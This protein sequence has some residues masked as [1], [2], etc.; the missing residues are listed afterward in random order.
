MSDTSKMDQIRNVWDEGRFD[1][2]W[3]IM[4]GSVEGTIHHALTSGFGRVWSLDSLFDVTLVGD[5]TGTGK[6]YE[7][8]FKAHFSRGEVEKHYLHTVGVAKITT[9]IRTVPIA[10][11]VRVHGDD[12]T[13]VRVY[14][15]LHLWWDKE[16]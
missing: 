15:Y 12:R 7:V 8:R 16:S 10:G 4:A 14:N 3:E 13:T 9:S 1:Q 11:T 2:G 6:E 5:E